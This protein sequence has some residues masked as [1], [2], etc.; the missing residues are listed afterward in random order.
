MSNRILRR[1]GLLAGLL[2]L[3]CATLVA[4][5]VPAAPVAPAN[6]VVQGTIVLIQ[7]T[8]RLD[9]RAVK[10]GDHFH[11]RL[12]EP[13]TAGNGTTIATGSKIKGHISALEPGLH[14]RI[15]LSFDEIET[16]R[17][18]VPL[19]ATV[20]GVPGEH[21]LKQ[22][23]EEG[24]I[25]RKGMSKEEIAEAVVVG[26]GEGAAEGMHSG[27]KKAAAA[28]AGAGAANSAFTAFESGHDLVL[29]KGTALEIRLDRNLMVPVR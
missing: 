5:D 25:G 3:F 1:T 11:A 26:A 10:A 22:I 29:D 23:G 24:E 6:A 15:L 12:A 17:G 4:Q 9:T 7:L 18:W 21:G 8:E 27:G 2:L 13:L 28:G 16:A 20:T 19:I 14:T